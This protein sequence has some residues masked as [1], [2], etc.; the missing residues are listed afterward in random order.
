[1]TFPTPNH[2]ES[3]ITSEIPFIG[4]FHKTLPH[5]EYG[6][7]DA[8]AYR[9][10]KNTCL[11]IEAGA[12]KNFEDVSGGTYPTNDPLVILTSAK[13]TSPLSG[14]AT[15]VHGPDPKGLEMLPAPD[16]LSDSTAAEMTELYW[17]ALLRDLPLASLA[18]D[19]TVQI[20]ASEIKNSFNPALNTI[21]S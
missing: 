8:S 18:T 5:N 13:Y 6:E 3:L 19:A 14:A 4:N 2:D 1:M 21:L 9:K 15:E 11:Q 7:V 20:A 12:P 10:F 16:I 17:M